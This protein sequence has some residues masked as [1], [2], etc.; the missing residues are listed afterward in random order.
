[1]EELEGGGFEE[2]IGQLDEFAHEGNEGDFGGFSGGA[3]AEVKRAQDGVAPSGDEGGH[4]E[5]R[6]SQGAT[7]ED[8]ALALLR[9]AVVVEGGHAGETGGLTR[10]QGAEFRDG[11]QQDP[12]GALSEALNLAEAGDLGGKADIGALQFGDLSLK[13]GEMGG[14]GFGELFGLAGDEGVVVM[15]GA[16]SFLD[17]QAEQLLAAAH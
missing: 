1:M 3:E 9:S 6:A 14:E 13:V 5:G 12:G 7:V 17:D 10:F 4:V 2:E 11:G 8:V 16:V 15:F